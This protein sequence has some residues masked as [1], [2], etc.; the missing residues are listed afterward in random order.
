MSFFNCYNSN[1][2]NSSFISLGFMIMQVR[3]GMQF[4]PPW[5]KQGWVFHHWWGLPLNCPAVIVLVASEGRSGLLPRGL[6]I[7][8]TQS[9]VV[10]PW[11]IPSTVG[12]WQCVNLLQ[13]IWD[14]LSILFFCFLFSFL[15]LH[16]ADIGGQGTT[17]EVVQSVMRVIQS[18]GQLTSEL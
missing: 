11:S 12:I 1:V 10:C 6:H 5:M 14:C 17:S 3:S 8:L 16:T 7:T 15:Q 4:S 13:L 18:K 2:N 9:R